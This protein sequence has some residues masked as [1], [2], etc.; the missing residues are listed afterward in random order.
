MKNSSRPRADRSLRTRI[1][2]GLAERSGLWDRLLDLPWL[3]A[4]LAIV[5]CTMLL[6]PRVGGHLPDWKVGDVA[7]FDVVVPRDLE[8]PDEVATEAVR[9]E[10]RTAVLPVYEFEPRLYVEL[11]EGIRELFAACR[12]DTESE[13]FAEAS[14]L[15]VEEPMI[16]IM[17]SSECG[18]D[19][20]LALIGVADQV[21]RT[22]IVDDMLA[23]ERR[24]ERGVTVRNLES[25]SERA[26]TLG[27]V[28]GAIDF[29]TGLETALRNG[30]LEREAVARRW[31][32]PAVD[33][34]SANLAPN[35][36][37]NRSETDGRV[38][39]AA[40]EVAPVS[41]VFRRGQVLVRRGDTVTFNVA[42][43]L[44]LINLQRQEVARFS[45]LVGIALLVG[46][47]VF[48]WWRLLS[49][50]SS[51]AGARRQL[52]MVYLLMLLF[53]ALDRIGVFVAT[54]IASSLSG[55]V[56]SVV[57]AYLWALPYAA[58]PVVVFVLLGAQPAVLFALFGSLIAG[59]MLGG[60]FAVVVYAL[61]AGLV[62]ALAMQRLSDRAVFSRA[63][64]AVGAANLVVFAVL[65]LFRGLPELPEIMVFAAAAAVVGGPL[66]VG[67]ASFLLPLLEGLFG[68]TTD[69][70]LLEL[71]NQNHPLLKRLS[72]QAPGTYQHSLAVGNLAEAGADAVGANSLLLRVCAYYHDV[73]K[74]VK[75]EYFVENQRGVNPHDSLSPS[76]SVLVIQSH[77]KEGLEMANRAKLPLPIRQAIAT[78]HGAKL[79]S[80]FFDKAQSQCDP[81]IQEVLESEFRYPGPKPPT[82]ELGI[83][84]LADAVEAAARTL[85]NPSPGK[86]Q[87][88]IDAIFTD[89]LEDDQLDDSDLTF[90]ELD[91]IASAFLWVLTNMYHHRID[92]PGFDFDR[93]RPRRDSGSYQVGAKTFAAGS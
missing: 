9:E 16:K 12:A 24:G 6:L 26:V 67:I 81:E 13:G 11:E 37:Y 4:V 92:Y 86:I 32:K 39:R 38:R 70:R 2:R 56:L 52:S 93:R 75:P 58:G 3:W 65:Q 45:T 64:L 90:A 31:I 25:G 23:L 5:G 48:G 8:V 59:V 55:P 30:L 42:R 69:I 36:Y 43:T 34:L 17:G 84:L 47:I 49:H 57:D 54:A 83:L 33:F 82:K 44:H 87:T 28:S 21:S 50:F 10:A 41:Q 15:R 80:Y 20:E 19:L 63:G 29:R 27:D 79:I 91:K 61:S 77:V 62:G 71:S 18:E 53:V 85:D 78:H 7:T 22:R 35:L 76:M 40:N 68:I 88:M 1:E 46:L 73:G 74:L 72:L 89:A 14:D 51:V 60:D 66:A